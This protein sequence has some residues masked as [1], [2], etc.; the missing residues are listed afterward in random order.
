MSPIKFLDDY[1]PDP[2]TKRIDPDRLCDGAIEAIAYPAATAGPIFGLVC[3]EIRSGKPA[4][5]CPICERRADVLDT[6]DFHGA[7]IRCLTHGE[8]EFS[9]SAFREERRFARD[10]WE[11]ALKRAQHRTNLGKRPRIYATDF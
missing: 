10:D 1:V 6:G 2:Q 8:F 4:P 9:R 7:A 5:I 11:T 3:G